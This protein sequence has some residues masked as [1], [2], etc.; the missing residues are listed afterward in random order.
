MAPRLD[1][2]DLLLEITD[3][4]Y[5]QPPSNIK[6]QFPCIVYQRE[7]GKSEYADNRPLWHTKRYQVTVIDRDPDTDLPDKV[8]ELPMS[9]FSRAF[10]ADDLNH[11][12]INLYF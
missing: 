9:E 3:H 4:V 7:G 6:L 11:Y 5:F 10:M 1:L 8:V 12:V 2:H